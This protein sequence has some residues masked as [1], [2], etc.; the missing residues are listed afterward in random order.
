MSA[1]AIIVG[2][3]FEDSEFQIPYERLQEAG[4]IVDI[5]GTEAGAAIKGKRDQSVARIDFSARAV[6]ADDY[7]LLV[8]P[9]GHSPDHLR[10]NP[11]VVSLVRGFSDAGKPIAAICHGP[12]LLIEAGVVRGRTLTS[13]A[14][15]KTDLVNAGAVWIDQAVVIDGNLIT[16]RKPADLDA[17]CDAIENS[18]QYPPPQGPQVASSATVNPRKHLSGLKRDEG[19]FLLSPENWDEHLALGLA[20]QEGLDELSEAQWQIIFALREHY[21]QHRNVPDFHHLCKSAHQDDVYCIE[22][23]FNNEGIKAWRIAGLPDPGEE[24]KAYL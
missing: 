12:Q 20:K 8:I 7:A 17:F 13:W 14:S 16:S 21:Q 5:I 9:G 10:T 22:R 24:A 19:G 23:H 6:S 11:D 15:V 4:Y 3:G 18:L 1:V 2:E